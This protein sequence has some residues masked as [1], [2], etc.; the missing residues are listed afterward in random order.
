MTKQPRPQKVHGQT[1][2]TPCPCGCVYTTVNNKDGKPFEVFARLGKSGG[3]GS[4]VV[5]AV[6][7]SISISLRSGGDIKD[8][9]KGIEGIS[10]HRPPAFDSGK[11]IYSCVDAI[12]KSIKSTI[13]QE[14]T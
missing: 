13:D 12:A 6:C 5:N 11:Q 4:T 9:I 10:C 2:E 14:E 7:A 3:C 8:H 1:I